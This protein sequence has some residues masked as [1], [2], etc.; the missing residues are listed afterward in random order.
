MK[1]S[2]SLATRG[3]AVAVVALGLLTAGA[4]SA[5]ATTGPGWTR[6]WNTPASYC[7]TVQGQYAAKGYLV[8]P[9][10]SYPGGAYFDYHR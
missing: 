3:I 10:V 9:C 5:S 1:N 2:S 4:S 8:G 6:V 7:Q